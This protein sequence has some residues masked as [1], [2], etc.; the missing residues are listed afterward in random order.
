MVLRTNVEVDRVVRGYH[1]LF[2]IPIFSQTSTVPNFTR[3][4]P[5]RRRHS[6]VDDIT[7]LIKDVNLRNVLRTVSSSR[8]IEI[9]HDIT[10][11]TIRDEIHESYTSSYTGTKTGCVWVSRYEVKSSCVKSLF[12]QVYKHITDIKIFVSVLIPKNWRLK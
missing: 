5:S 11:H 4:H 6:T 8:Y 1:D 12:S 2:G 10:N 3:Q 7:H 9:E